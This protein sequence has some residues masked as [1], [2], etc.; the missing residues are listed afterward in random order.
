MCVAERDDAIFMVN[1]LRAALKFQMNFEKKILRHRPEDRRTDRSDIS[2]ASNRELWTDDST[3]WWDFMRVVLA[4][5]FIDY[6]DI[7]IITRYEK[8]RKGRRSCGETTRLA[9]LLVGVTV[10]VTR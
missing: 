1:A 4:R 3:D 9:L 7:H 10:L 2:F 8:Q 5:D 6:R